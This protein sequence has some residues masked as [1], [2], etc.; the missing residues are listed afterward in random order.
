MGSSSRCAALISLISSCLF[1]FIILFQLPLFRVPCRIGICTTPI[2]VTASQLIATKT[3][4][5]FFAKALLYPGCIA[6]AFINNEKIPSFS[7]VVKLYNLKHFKKGLSA[8]ELQCLEIL[9][10][11]CLAVVGALLGIIK[12]GR[13]SLIGILLTLWGFVR[14]RIQRK[15]ATTS[16]S[17]YPFAMSFALLCAWLSIRKDVR[18]LVRCFKSRSKSKYM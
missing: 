15:Y 18:K 17:V 5:A 6:Q 2:E 9:A 3:C 1:F 14:Q 12:P 11:S 10:G 8:I 7:Q 4:P 13:M 16:F